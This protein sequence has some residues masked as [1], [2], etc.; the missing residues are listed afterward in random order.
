MNLHSLTLA[1][2]IVLSAALPSFAQAMDPA[3]MTCKD[4]TAMDAEGMKKA[5]TDLKAAAMAD[6]M[7]DPA[8]MKM[9]DEDMMKMMSAACDGKPDMMMM[10]TMRS[11]G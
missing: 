9:S 5:M 7:A 8:K 2:A 3:K 11:G 6:T 10:D 1:A 4:Y